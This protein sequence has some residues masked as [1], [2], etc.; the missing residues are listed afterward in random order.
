LKLD[1]NFI[2]EE[3]FQGL[4]VAEFDFSRETVKENLEKISLLS[5]EYDLFVQKVEQDLNDQKASIKAKMQG[6]RTKKKD[7]SETLWTLIQEQLDDDTEVKKTYN[8]IVNYSRD[9]GGLLEMQKFDV[10]AKLDRLFNEVEMRLSKH[11]EAKSDDMNVFMLFQEAINNIVNEVKEKFIFFHKVLKE[12]NGSVFKSL[13]YSIKPYGEGDFSVELL[14]QK[15]DLHN[16]ANF[17]Y[18]GNMLKNCVI[19]EINKDMVKFKVLINNI[20]NHFLF[21]ADKKAIFSLRVDEFLESYLTLNQLFAPFVIASRKYLKIVLTGG[22]NKIRAIKRREELVSL[23]IKLTDCISKVILNKLKTPMMLEDSLDFVRTINH[24]FTLKQVLEFSP[25]NILAVYQQ[26]PEVKKG[27]NDKFLIDYKSLLNIEPKIA[28]QLSQNCFKKVIS[29]IGKYTDGKIDPKAQAIVNKVQG[30]TILSKEN[31][32]VCYVL[33]LFDLEELE[34]M[35]KTYSHN[36]KITL[37]KDYYVFS[38][39]LDGLLEIDNVIC[40]MEYEVS[41][42]HIEK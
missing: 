27:P 34:L 42:T 20:K 15:R 32:K 19:Q 25:K 31:H 39:S 21:Q 30:E 28:K 6:F 4:A 12:S 13:R 7:M 17:S 38:I 5:E 36:H 29:I 1:I 2:S 18:F 9:Y 37:R 10:N 23:K 24:N 41:Y 11:I 40:L 16:N 33:N 26:M 22:L 8:F 35:H 3:E 14:P